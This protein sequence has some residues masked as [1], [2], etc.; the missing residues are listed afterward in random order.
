M[1]KYNYY[2]DCKL[3]HYAQS[4]SWAWAANLWP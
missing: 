4:F 1:L 2:K 3:Y